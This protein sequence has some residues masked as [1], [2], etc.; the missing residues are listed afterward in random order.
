MIR[1]MFEENVRKTEARGLVQWDYGQILQIEGLKGIDHAEVHFAVKECSAKAEICIATI[2]EN[3]IL[4]DIPDKLLEV[5]KDLIAYVYIADAMSGKTVR[6]IELPVKKR[7]QPGDYSTPSGEN[8][9]RQVLES[10]EKKADNMTVIDGELQLL[11]GDTPVGNRVRMET[12]AGKEIEI[13]NDGTSIQWRYTDQN[14]WKELIPLADLKGEDGK[15]P[16]FEIREGHLIV[17]YE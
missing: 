14:E 8:L 7:E 17:K 5:G 11:S 1:A 6:I 15:P 16:E 13:R 2:E 10:L 3:R 4:A 9:L 12:A